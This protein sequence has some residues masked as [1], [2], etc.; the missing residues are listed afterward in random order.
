ML[1]IPLG[2]T[3]A[4]GQDVLNGGAELSAR[5][6]TRRTSVRVIETGETIAM[7]APDQVLIEGVLAS[8]APISIHYR[9]GAPRGTGFLW[10]I[11]GT[12]GDIQVTGANGHAQLVQLFIETARG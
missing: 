12:E 6:A 4:A 9:G 10:E 5:L 1:T 3:L 11:N 2:H 7:T 8:G